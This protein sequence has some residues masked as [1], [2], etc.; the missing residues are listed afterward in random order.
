MNLMNWNPSYSTVCTLTIRRVRRRY[1]AVREAIKHTP[2]H[3]AKKQYDAKRARAMQMLEEAKE[4]SEQYY[5]AQHV[6][7][8]LAALKE[9][10]RRLE[11][12]EHMEAMRRKGWV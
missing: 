8:E 12:L 2:S 9:E 10:V 1:Y 4:R 5:R 7:M 3:T 11:Y 6:K